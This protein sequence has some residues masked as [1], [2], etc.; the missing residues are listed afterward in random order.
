MILTKNNKEMFLNPWKRIRGLPKIIDLDKNGNMVTKRVSADDFI[1]VKTVMDSK[2]VPNAANSNNVQVKNHLPRKNIFDILR[3]ASGGDIALKPERS[4]I[5]LHCSE[6]FCRFL[7]CP[8]IKQFCIMCVVPLPHST[9][10]NENQLTTCHKVS[11][12][13]V[14]SQ[15]ILWFPWMHHK[16]LEDSE[17]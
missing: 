12:E 8:N 7:T 14:T 1:N 10:N 4:K 15:G 3:N 5:L 2:T 13:S 6:E 11:T 17:R 9:N 16:E